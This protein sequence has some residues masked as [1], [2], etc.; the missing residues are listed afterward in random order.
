MGHARRP[1]RRPPQHRSTHAVIATWTLALLRRRRGRLA[2]TAAGI[3]TAVALLACL[4]G[5]LSAAQGSMTARAIRSV[6]IDWQ[7]EVQPDGQPSTALD[8]VQS[9]AGVRATLPV[10]FAHSTGLI[11]QSGGSTQTTGPAMVLGIPPSYR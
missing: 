1:P 6:T 10:G 4:G 8:P 3:A 9:T 5:S 11:A 2:A 7:I